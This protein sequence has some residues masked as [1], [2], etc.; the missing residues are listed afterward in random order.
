MR[1]GLGMTRRIRPGT[2]PGGERRTV[3]VRRGY[4]GCDRPPTCL[5]RHCP[6]VIEYKTRGRSPRQVCAGAVRPSFLKPH[7][8]STRR[9]AR[10]SGSAVA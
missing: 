2:V 5:D 8:C 3:V 9:D 10:F 1:E 4:P 7:F 6:A